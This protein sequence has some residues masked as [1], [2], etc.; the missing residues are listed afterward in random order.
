MLFDWDVRLVCGAKCVLK[1]VL[2]VVVPC[3]VIALCD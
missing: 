1:P 3:A 2:F